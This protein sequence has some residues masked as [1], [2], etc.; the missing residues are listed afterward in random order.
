MENIIITGDK[1]NDTS[2]VI[3]EKPKEVTFVEAMTIAYTTGI[4]IA[5]KAHPNQPKY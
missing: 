4:Y 5:P 3:A 1:V 2:V